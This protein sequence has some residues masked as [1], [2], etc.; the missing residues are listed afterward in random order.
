MT[1][2]K[3]LSALIKSGELSGKRVFIRSD[4]NV[5]FDKTGKI[6]ED[7][8][9]RA[10]VPGIR[11]ALSAGAAVMITSHLSRPKKLACIEIGSLVLV[12]QRLSELL[13][14]QVELIKDWINGV[15]VAPGQVV[16][17]EN[18]RMNI[19]E[20]KNDEILSR[21]MASLC[22]IYVNDAFGTA[23]RIEST[24]YGMARFSPI[25]CA[26]PLLETELNTLQQV[27]KEPK[28]PLVAVIGGSKIS[29]KL[30]IL[31]SLAEKVDRLI[32]GGGIANTFMLANG[33]SI[34]NSLAEPEKIEQTK[35]I[36]SI[37][38]NRGFPIPIPED[39]VCAKSVRSK[40]SITKL[41]NQ[42]SID[43]LILDI[44]PITACKI[45][46]LLKQAGTIIWNGPVG[47]FE[48]DSFSIGTSTIAN[49]I[50]ESEGFSIA[51]GGETLAVIAKYGIFDKI[52]YVSTGGGAFLKLLAGDVL[53]AVEILEER[54]K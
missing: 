34:G 29:T 15:K 43:D 8:R 33:Q 36:M 18:C 25:A 31:Y 32:V 50:A 21:K 22:D 38:K 28:R 11:L 7:T 48:F 23:H 44:G 9:I 3:T 5:P 49:A 51:G 16:L 12:A 53:P 54:A 2:I 52:G 24:T 6:L 30:P 45:A 41:V 19:G 27:F 13:G 46:E 47:M 37:M 26:G 1:Q 39:V 40:T 17:L 20:E 14:T 35:A 4:L 10:S 42:I